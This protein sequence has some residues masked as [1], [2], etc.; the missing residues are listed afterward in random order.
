M[1]IIL[2]PL[3]FDNSIT[4][5]GVLISVSLMLLQSYL[6]AGSVRRTAPASALFPQSAGA[7]SAKFL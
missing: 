7:A 6:V 5:L 4:L 1:S 3:F 2:A